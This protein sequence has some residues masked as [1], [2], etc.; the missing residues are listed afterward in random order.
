MTMT[1]RALVDQLFAAVESK[2]VAA[3]LDFFAED[4][5]IID[6]HYPTP[7]MADKAAMAE[8][9]AWAFGTLEKMGFTAVHYFEAADGQSAAV[10]MDTAHRLPGGRPLNFRQTFVIETRDGRVTRLQSYTPYGPPG[11][12]G[13][14]LK[15]VRLRRRLPRRRST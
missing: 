14:I 13:L 2:N 12:G 7:R 1:L 15:L 9:L 5:V 6:P 3:V 8:G 4:S 10:E 11:I